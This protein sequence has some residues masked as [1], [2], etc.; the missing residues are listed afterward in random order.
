MLVLRRR[1]AAIFG[2]ALMLSRVLLAA[3]ESLGTIKQRSGIKADADQVSISGLSAGAYM[4]VQYHIAHSSQIMGV[5]IIAGGPYH[6]A[7]SPSAMC[8]YSPYAMM[9]SG[10][11]RAIHVCTR[12]AAKMTWWDPLYFGPP[13]Y[14][15]SIASTRLE[16]QKGTIDALPGLKKDKVWIF[17]GTHDSMVPSEIV[18]QVRNYYQTLFSLPEVG[19]RAEDITFIDRVPV[20]HSI[21]LDKEET[22]H[23]NDCDRFGPPFIDHCSYAAA[24]NLLRF[25]Y[26]EREESSTASTVGELATEQQ[27]RCEP[28]ASCAK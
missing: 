27:G 5:G 28:P 17:T 20:E 7:A 15:Y 14:H 4:A 24:E 23:K 16:A 22:T 3:P 25:I 13:D 19:N 1:F 21:V 8:T 2:L 12:T 6:C 26:P 11:C 18:A 10:L 9:D